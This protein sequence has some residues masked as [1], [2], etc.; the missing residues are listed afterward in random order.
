LA[1]LILGIVGSTARAD[2]FSLSTGTSQFDTGVNNSGWW[3]PTGFNSD[4]NDNYVVG[5]PFRDFFTFDLLAAPIPSGDE[6]VAATLK[7]TRRLSF[8]INQNVETL[9]FHQV[10]TD[11]ATL[12]NNEG[13]SQSIFDDLGSGTS[14]GSFNVPGSGGFNDVL[15]FALNDN[16]IADINAGINGFFSIGGDLTS[17]VGNEFLFADSGGQTATLDI[18]TEPVPVPAPGAAMLGIM[19]LS[20]VGWLKWRVS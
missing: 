19:G 8:G 3:S 20:L 12:N 5:S 1:G 10:T 11:A 15:F 18:V 2:L 13:A 4:T 14:Y 6:V 16:A 7:I 9:A 17:Q